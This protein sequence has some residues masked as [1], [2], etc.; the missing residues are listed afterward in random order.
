MSNKENHLKKYLKNKIFCAILKTEQE[1]EY[2]EER[3]IGI[4]SKKGSF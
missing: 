1:F 2:K 4:V 3:V